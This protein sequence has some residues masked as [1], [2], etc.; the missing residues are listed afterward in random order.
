VSIYGGVAPYDLRNSTWEIETP[1]LVRNAFAVMDRFAP[2]F[3]SSVTATKVYT[4]KDIETILGMPGGNTLH[5]EMTID[6]LFFMRP[7][8]GYA[9]YRSPIALLYQCGASTHPGGAVSGVPGHNAAREILRD[10][11]R[12]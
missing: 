10:F 5:G 2:G 8:P 9:D 12:L 4:P 6:Q 7:A 1:N 3:S 11:P